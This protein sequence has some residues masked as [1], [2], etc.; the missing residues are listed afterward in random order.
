MKLSGESLIIKNT[1]VPATNRKVFVAASDDSYGIPLAV[2]SSDVMEEYCELLMGT[3]LVPNNL[4]DGK[5]EVLF[6]LPQK[7]DKGMPIGI[8]FDLD[9]QGRLRLSAVDMTHS[10]TKDAEFRVGLSESAMEEAKRK[11]GHLTA[12]EN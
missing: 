11:L 10:Q 4:E 1:P 3:K 8:Q 2:Y 9:E 7:L 5:D 6:E 12:N